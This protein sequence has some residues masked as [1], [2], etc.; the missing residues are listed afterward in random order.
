MKLT[1]HRRY[2]GTE[3][4]IGTLYID[5]VKFSD[6]LEDRDRGLDAEMSLAHIIAKKIFG[7]TAIPTGVYTIDMH[8]VSPKFKNRLW[9]QPYNGV[10]PRLLNVKGFSGVLIHPLNTADESFGCIGVGENK[11]KGKIINST[12]TF[13][14]L[15]TRLL[16]ADRRG[17]I[18]TI[19]IL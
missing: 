4:T 15:M 11:V 17:E 8:T 18:I 16:E 14:K 9:A 10:V 1:L 5:G 7:K 13:H 3:Y 19:E 12:V 2:K 6:T